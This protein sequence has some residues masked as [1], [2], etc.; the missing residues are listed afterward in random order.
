MK[1]KKLEVRITEYEYSQLK[2]EAER[3]G[4][5]ISELI[6]SCIAKFP[7]PKMTHDV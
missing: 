7:E 5:T 2:Q 3:R 4:M 6:R 1:N